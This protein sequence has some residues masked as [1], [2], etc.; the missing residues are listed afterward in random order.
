MLQRFLRLGGGGCSERLNNFFQQTFLEGFS[1]IL[2]ESKLEVR[3]LRSSSQW[4]GSVIRG[5]G[6][7]KRAGRILDSVPRPPWAHAVHPELGS[8]SNSVM[9]LCV[10][11]ARAV[12]LADCL[13][14]TFAEVTPQIKKGWACTTWS[15]TARGQLLW[16]TQMS[17]CDASD[18]RRIHNV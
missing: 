7:A 13:T 4:R 11:A 16:E 1:V 6:Q 15:S 9:W 10:A 2:L 12:N 8:V 17:G 5:W 14:N 3:W 18:V